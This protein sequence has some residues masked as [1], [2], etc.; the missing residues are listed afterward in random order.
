MRV[1]LIIAASIVLTGCMAFPQ[2]QRQLVTQEQRESIAGATTADVVRHTR[3]EAP[4]SKIETTTKDGTTVKIEQ[5]V[6]FSEDMAARTSASENSD[7]AASG[8]ASWEQSIPLGAKLI[9]LAIGV[10]LLLLIVWLIRRSSAAANAAW[11]YGDEALKRRIDALRSRMATAT[12][13]QVI[14]ALQQEEAQLE[15]E[16]AELNAD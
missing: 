16:R 13:P 7:S 14:M 10:G 5:P 1:L 3:V 12:E 6:A 8:V 9:L 15:R 4:T 11:K 2:E